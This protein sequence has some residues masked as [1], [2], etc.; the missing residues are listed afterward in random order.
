LAICLPASFVFQSDGDTPA[1]FCLR[2]LL[3]GESYS[4]YSTCYRLA[5]SLKC[6]REEEL[7]DVA[8]MR[9]QPVELDRRNRAE[10][11]VRKNNFQTLEPMF[12]N[13]SQTISDVWYS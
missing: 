10:V 5:G 2:K 8:L 1:R 7:D 9:L 4:R 3:L 12:A 6:A 13:S 11:V